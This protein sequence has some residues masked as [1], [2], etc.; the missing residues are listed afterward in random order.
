VAPLD[1]ATDVEALRLAVSQ[2][3][4]DSARFTLE[5]EGVFDLTNQKTRVFNT[6]GLSNDRI[7]TLSA[8]LSA[9]W[10]PE[11]GGH[12][13]AAV[14]LRKGLEVFGASRPGDA[15]LSRFGA[16]PQ[17]FVARFRSDGE[18]P[19]FRFVRLFGRLEGQTTDHALTAPE[20][21]AVGNLSIGR[22]YEPGSAFGDRA[23]AVSG[24]VRIGPLPVGRRFQLEPF[25][26]Y[27]AARLWTL[28]PGLHT[29][30]DIASWG[31]GVRLDLP[32]KLHVELFYADP[33]KPPQGSGQPTPP[34]RLF[35]N[36]TVGL[37]D[38]F[39]AVA[40]RTSEGGGQ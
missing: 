26:F 2:P 40:R 33:L 37:N 24:E 6:V 13:T 29:R 17:A 3:F 5:G 39:S 16:D 22:G 18:T 9:A 20:Q 25:V 30:R 36:V 19:T 35:L 21:Y 1:I 31:G 32:G 4:L 34:A 11:P 23:L 15:S 12:L 38:V 28:T 10:R 7:R 27:D 8:T 14:E